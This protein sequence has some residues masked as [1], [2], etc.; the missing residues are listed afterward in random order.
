M[1]FYSINAQQ[2]IDLPIS[3][4]GLAYG[5]GVFSTAK[6]LDGQVMMLTQHLERLGLGCHHLGFLAPDLALLKQQLGQIAK[7]FKRAVIKVIISAGQGGRGYS[8]RGIEQSNTIISVHDFP[9]H[10][11]RWQSEGINLGLSALKLGLN[12]MLAGIKHLNRLEQVF[13][14]QELDAR[15]EDDL[16]VRDINDNLVEA[17]CA[18]IFWYAAKQWHTPLIADAGINGLMRQHVLAH[19]PDTRVCQAGLSDISPAS[20][21]FICN[22]VMGLVPVRQYNGKKLNIDRVIP[23]IKAVM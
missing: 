4:R 3:D 12:P 13:V 19:F 5:D 2:D 9:K 22:S 6:I 21:M 8:R 11:D 1:L 20:A 17:S 23:L 7:P 18:N 16:L 15:D 10:Y 14:R